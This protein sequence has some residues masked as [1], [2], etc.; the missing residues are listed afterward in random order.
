MTDTTI[1]APKTH[2]VDRR[3][4]DLVFTDWGNED[5]L[6]STAQLA[7]RLGTSTQFLTIGRHRG[8]GPPYLRISY[9][10]TRYRVGDV[11]KWLRER[12][13]CSTAEYMRR[14]SGDEQAA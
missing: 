14:P 5:D 4:S 6:L 9:K 2:H 1:Q 10:V 3:A 7:E 8:Y 12:T 13:Y 11:K